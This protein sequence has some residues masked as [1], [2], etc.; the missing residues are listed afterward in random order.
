MP[1]VHMLYLN[2]GFAYANFA[3]AWSMEAVH[4]KQDSEFS[5]KSGHD[6]VMAINH[7]GHFLLTVL[8]APAL[9]PGASIVVMGSHGMW[10]CGFGRLMP[11]QRPRWEAR[12]GA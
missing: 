5:S 4:N 3:T 10:H 1:V 11:Q 12:D 6:R 9:A 7:L 8:L 2:A